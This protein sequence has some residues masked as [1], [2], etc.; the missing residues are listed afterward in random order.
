MKVTRSRDVFAI[1]CFLRQKFFPHFFRCLPLY[2]STGDPTSGKTLEWM[3]KQPG[4]YR[5]TLTIKDDTSFICKLRVLKCW[6]FWDLVSLKILI[7]LPNNGGLEESVII[8]NFFP[9]SNSNSLTW[10]FYEKRKLK[11]GQYCNTLLIVGLHDG[12][13]SFEVTFCRCAHA[14]RIT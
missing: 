11:I 7:Y 10:P 1:T 12:D 14:N 5:N 6:K 9:G 13:T 3:A 4:H 8:L 2:K